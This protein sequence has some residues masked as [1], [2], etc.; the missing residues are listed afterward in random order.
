MF[1]TDTNFFNYQQ[2]FMYQHNLSHGSID[3]K[4]AVESANK[5]KARAVFGHCYNQIDSS[6]SLTQINLSGSSDGT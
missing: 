4:S 5:G 6:G 3:S 2:Q 1:P